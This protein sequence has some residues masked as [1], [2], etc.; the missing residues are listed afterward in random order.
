L[1]A[2]RKFVGKVFSLAK[3]PK[4]EVE[5]IN[6]M[7]TW[8]MVRR[9]SRL[10][11]MLQLTIGLYEC[12]NCKTKFRGMLGKEKI[13]IKGIMQKIKVLEEMVMEA[14]KKRTELEEKVKALEE[15]KACLL[16]EV[17]ALKAIPELEAKISALEADIAKLKEEKKALEEKITPPAPTPPPPPA[18][19]VPAEAPAPGEEKP[20]EEKPCE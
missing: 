20:C 4:C 16:A 8:S 17:E 3:C 12:T 15:E 11:E 5:V 13:T 1:K 6:P 10:G 19:A 2:V 14:A 7:K 18:E 9:P